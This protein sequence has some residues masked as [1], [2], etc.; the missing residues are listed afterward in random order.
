MES[1]LQRD[2]FS[3]HTHA[4]RTVQ[5]QSSQ[6]Q[7]QSL[8]S[9]TNIILR[10]TLLHSSQD[11]H[12]LSFISSLMMFHCLTHRSHFNDTW[13]G[14]GH[15][16]GR[17]GT[18]TCLLLRIMEPK[19]LPSAPIFPRWLFIYHWTCASQENHNTERKNTFN[20]H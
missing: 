6:K 11:S 4:T 16:R 9:L 10:G 17:G 12:G 2:L 20:L 7:I 15:S 1:F 19:W 3:H 14:G 13:R 8:S 5:T 18:L